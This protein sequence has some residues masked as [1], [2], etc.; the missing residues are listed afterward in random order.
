MELMNLNCEEC[1]KT[2]N[3]CCKA[4][5]PHDIVT[6]LA[7]V[8]MGE[9]KGLKNLGITAHPN[10]ETRAII[11]DKKW[12]KGNDLNIEDKPCVFL[13]DGKCIVYENR[14]DICRLYGTE[15]VRCRYEASGISPDKIDK[16]SIQ[17]IKHL[18]EYAKDVS[19][20]NNMM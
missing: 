4:D 3:H 8:A 19:R 18:D 15:F 13:K 16:L 10:H 11:F 17:D 2:K 9:D 1:T 12:I 7:L 6:A 14:P 20:I 5:I